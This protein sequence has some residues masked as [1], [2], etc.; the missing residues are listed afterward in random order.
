MA[1]METTVVST[2]MPTVVRELGG[3]SLYAWVFTAYM[4][5]STVMVPL[6]GKLADIYG[7][8]PIMCA[9]RSC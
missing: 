4:L 1:A 5:A 2:A 6:Y 3:L 8:K 7:R 9:N